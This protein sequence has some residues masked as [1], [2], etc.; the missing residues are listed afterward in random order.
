M[1]ASGIYRGVVQSVDDPQARRRV[2]V[3]IPQ[4]TGAAGAWAES[5][6]PPVSGFTLPSVGAVVWVVFEGGDISKPVWLGTVT[7]QSDTATLPAVSSKPGD[8]F[9]SPIVISG[10]S[11]FID[12]DLSQYT[13][14]SFEGTEGIYSSAWVAAP[15][16]G[17]LA[18]SVVNSTLLGVQ[19]WVGGSTSP[20]ITSATVSGG[21]L[22]LSATVAVTDRIRVFGTSPTTASLT[23]TF[24]AS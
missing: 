19:R 1:M 12:F 9:S 24:T 22:V 16:P 13:T 17:V 14:E 8:T 6:V 21:N 5:V 4:F 11:G 7:T 15:V 23:W 10:T 20:T 18:V 3:A 2:L